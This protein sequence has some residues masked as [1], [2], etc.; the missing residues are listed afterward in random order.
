MGRRV[1]PRL[2]LGI[3]EGGRRLSKLMLTQ[4]KAQEILADKKFKK[5][6]RKGK[7]FHAAESWRCRLLERRITLIRAD[8]R[9]PPDAA[10]AKTQR[11]KCA[12]LG[13]S[14]DDNWQSIHYR[15]KEV[16]GKTCGT[17][18]IAGRLQPYGALVVLTFIAPEMVLPESADVVRGT[19]LAAGS[20]GQ[21]QQKRKRGNS[22]TRKRGL[23]RL[24][25]KLRS[26]ENSGNIKIPQKAAA[27]SLGQR[28]R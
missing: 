7:K 1:L 8:N 18:T 16:G 28:W 27:A 9:E 20:E 11:L 2:I 24:T 10:H 12:A 19:P 6:F 5:P 21:R 14:D 17:Y 22:I 25:P 4:E 15:M 3:F 23:L 13:I 26:N